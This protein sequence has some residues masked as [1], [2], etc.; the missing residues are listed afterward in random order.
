MHM[1]TMMMLTNDDDDDGDDDDDIDNADAA[2]DDRYVLA[3]RCEGSQDTD[4][5]GS[6]TRTRKDGEKA[7]TE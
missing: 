4:T 6:Q 5:Q 2:G 3:L 7:E 1:V